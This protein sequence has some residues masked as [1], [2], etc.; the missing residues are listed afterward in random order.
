MA[1]PVTVKVAQPF[2]SA[3]NEPT[4][5]FQIPTT[6]GFSTGATISQE[7]ARQ[8]IKELQRGL[9]EIKKS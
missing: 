4:L 6:P 1:T 7:T 3:P 9:T 5:E 8:L 2:A